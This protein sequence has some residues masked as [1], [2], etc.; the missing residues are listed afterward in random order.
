MKKIS[1]IIYLQNGNLL[2]ATMHGFVYCAMTVISRCKFSS[3]INL[4]YSG[5]RDL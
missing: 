4:H 5:R 3:H 1:R 2:K